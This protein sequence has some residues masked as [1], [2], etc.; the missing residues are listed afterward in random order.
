MQDSAAAE[1][2]RQWDAG[3]P[4]TLLQMMAAADVTSTC[5]TRPEGE[6]RSIGINHQQEEI[7]AP[8]AAS[9]HRGLIVLTFSTISIDL[10]SNAFQRYCFGSSNSFRETCLLI[11][12]DN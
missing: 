1:N 10:I 12:L 5:S 2:R 7:K 4:Q 3:A 11:I 8:N 6:F 9:A